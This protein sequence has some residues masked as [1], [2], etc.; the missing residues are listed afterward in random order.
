MSHDFEE[1]DF[2]LSLPDFYQIFYWLAEESNTPLSA[3]QQV[4]AMLRIT[5]SIPHDTQLP[6]TIT[7]TTFVTFF[8]DFYVHHNVLK[9]CASTHT[10]SSSKHLCE[11][12]QPDEHVTNP[13]IYPLHRCGEC[14]SDHGGIGF[15]LNVGV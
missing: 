8:E 13:P 12:L 2:T 15:R 5:C 11:I 9:T 4:N 6:L 3:K 1:G 10:T 7:F 14:T